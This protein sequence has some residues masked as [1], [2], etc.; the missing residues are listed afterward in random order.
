MDV[1]EVQYTRSGDVAIAYQV[2]GDGERDLVLVPFLANIYS[3]W[4]MYGFAGFGQALASSRRLIV[5]NPR[6]VGLSDRPRGFTVESRMDDIR[7]VMDALG[8]ERAALLGL[9]ES[10]ATCAVFAA[11]YPERV[12]HLLLWMPFVRFVSNDEDRERALDGIRRERERWGDRDQLTEMARV[13]NPQWADNDEYLDSFVWHHRLT[14][15]PATIVEFRRMQVDLDISDVLPAIRV[16]TLVMSKEHQRAGADEVAAAI[17]DA[18]QVVVPG[19]GYAIWE[20]DLPLEALESFL[21]GS[22]PRRVPDTVLATLL[23]TDLVGSTEHAAKLG[24]RAWRELLATQRTLVRRELERYRGEEVDTAGDGFF[25][26]FDGPAR[27][28]SCARAVVDRTA[29]LGL[30]IRGGIHTGECELVDGKP[31][32][33]SVHVGARVCARAGPGEVLVSGTV[34]DLVAGSDL[35]FDARGEHE[36]KGV[37][38]SWRLYAVADG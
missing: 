18:E 10:A 30:S 20:N 14:A 2:V 32:G 24:D 17:P 33:L 31:A 16:P 37:P 27:A 15:S 38:G 36:L 8:S 28:I 12:D 7:A 4:R 3:L 25:A 26:R 29:E 23:F 21:E 5:V 13:L 11:S 22:P 6:G 34:K 35:A 19:E 9:A 1:P